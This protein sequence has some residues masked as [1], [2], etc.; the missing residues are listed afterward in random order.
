M[1]TWIN[2]VKIIGPNQ[3]DQQYKNNFK[4]PLTQRPFFQ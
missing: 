3:R 2:E 1:K 4:I